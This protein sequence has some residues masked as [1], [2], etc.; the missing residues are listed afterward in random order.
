MMII[1]TI[2]PFYII[3]FTLIFICLLDIV[4][5][6]LIYPFFKKQKIKKAIYTTALKYNCQCRIFKEKSHGADFIIKVDNIEYLVKI[7][8]TKK[9]CDLQINNKETFMMYLK[10]NKNT[11]KTKPL[12]SLSSFMNS[13]KENRI[14]LLANKAKTIKKTINECEMIMVDENVDVYGVH[15]LNYNQYDYFFKNKIINNKSK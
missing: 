5:K 7:L 11:M 1:L 15:I 10:N 13:R 12:H 3:T 8:Y 2:Q 14:L 4:F 9:N 6:L